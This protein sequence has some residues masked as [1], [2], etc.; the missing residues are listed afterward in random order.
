MLLKVEN[1]RSFFFLDEGIL[2]AVDDIS[3]HVN[4]EE[5]VALVGESGCGKT[6]AALSII[7]LIPSPGRVVKGKVYF[8]GQD[9][10]KM[11]PEKMRRTRGKEI[12][13]VFQEPSM[14]L[15]PVFTVGSQITEILRLHLG[16]AIKEAEREAIR[17]LGETGIPEPEKRFK[18]YPF[19]LSGGMQQRALIALAVSCHPRLLIADEPTTALDVT[20]QIGIIDLLRHLQKLYDMAILLITHD[21][22]VVAEMADRIMVMYTGK[23]VEN[24]PAVDIFKEPKHPYTKGLLGSIPKL[25]KG[26]KNP[27]QGIPGAVPDFLDLPP[28]CTFHPRCELGDRDCRKKFP[29]LFAVD[30]VRQSACYKYYNM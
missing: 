10:L 27:L 2:R 5:T 17:L 30:Y 24:A 6:I 1:L 19:E 29:K 9:L 14:S 8:N 7:N 23:I 28:G 15:N 13:F 3:F 11:N 25:G 18:A 16:M 21:L 20:V 22:G 4:E 12:G 26:S